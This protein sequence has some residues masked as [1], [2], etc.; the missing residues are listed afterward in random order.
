MESFMGSTHVA[1]EQGLCSHG[2]ACSGPE[3]GVQNIRGTITTLKAPRNV[4]R[5]PNTDLAP[6]ALCEF[7]KSMQ[8]HWNG[9]QGPLIT[10]LSKFR[11][12]PE[13]CEVRRRVL[14]KI[15]KKCISRA[16]AP[17]GRDAWEPLIDI[18]SDSTRV[19][20]YKSI[21]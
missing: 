19:D 8:T 13:W 1:R 4:V 15:C 3:S 6:F 7:C 20:C 16:R 2:C 12:P 10:S 9:P 18:K 5:I 11:S 17:R 14:Y 21:T